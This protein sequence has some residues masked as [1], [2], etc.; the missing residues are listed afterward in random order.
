MA[1]AVYV[2]QRAVSGHNP[3]ILSFCISVSCIL[4]GTF[5]ISSKSATQIQQYSKACQKIRPFGPST[6]TLAHI[7]CIIL[8]IHGGPMMKAYGGSTISKMHHR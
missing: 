4:I 6:L 8:L 7:T 1:R 3:A 2:M 5:S